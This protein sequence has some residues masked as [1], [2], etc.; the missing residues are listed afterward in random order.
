MH[1]KPTVVTTVVP[2]ETAISVAELA[3]PGLPEAPVS[4]A[5]PSIAKASTSR[6][7]YGPRDGV[8][9]ADRTKRRKRTGK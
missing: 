8:E 7:D 1:R 6:G 9:Y 5:I 4:P 2:T 3:D